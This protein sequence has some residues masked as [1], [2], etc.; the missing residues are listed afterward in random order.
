VAV[1]KPETDAKADSYLRTWALYG[2]IAVFVLAAGWWVIKPKATQ[3]PS[4]SAIL[5]TA[6]HPPPKPL[7]A[8]G[9]PVSD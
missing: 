6:P 3:S 7:N 9:A 5:A 4:G 1:E 2:F 8:D